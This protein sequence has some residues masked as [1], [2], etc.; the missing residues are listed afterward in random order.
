M[1]YLHC[2]GDKCG[3]SQDD[4]WSYNHSWKSW[5]QF[6]TLQW[7]RRPFGYNPFSIL[8]EDIAEYIVPRKIKMDSYWAKE[9]GLKS[10]EVWSWWFIKK[11][12]QRYRSV[13]KTMLFKTQDEFLANKETP[14]PKCGEVNW[15]ID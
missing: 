3:W 9:N 15:D 12:F 10:D 1:A 14:C 5:K 11:G 6:L 2:H 13:K 7:Q 8:L 4:F